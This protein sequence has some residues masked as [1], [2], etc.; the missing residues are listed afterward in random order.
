MIDLSCG[1]ADATGHKVWLG[2]SLFV[3]F[4]WRAHSLRNFFGVAV[5]L[6]CGTGLGGLALAASTQARLV[7]LTDGHAG[8]CELAALNA[9]GN[10]ATVGGTKV[11]VRRLEWG[12]NP[13]LDDADIVTR[14]AVRSND[15]GDGNEDGEEKQPGLS[16]SAQIEKAHLVLVCDA[17]Y[18]DSVVEILVQTAVSLLAKHEAN[19]DTEIDSA[20]SSGSGVDE[21]RS[22]GLLIVSHVPRCAN[23]AEVRSRIAS[24]AAAAGLHQGQ[25]TTA[26]ELFLKEPAVVATGT[27]T[28]S[29]A[30]ISGAAARVNR[31]KLRQDCCGVGAA[32]FVASTSPLLSIEL[33]G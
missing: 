3:E 1:T 11:E 5:E 14:Q 26:E 30:A 6:G 29:A 15:E 22:A 7:V 8:V 32:I 24:S 12:Q 19:A 13:Q 31:E 21:K 16:T 4:L 17:I 2:A 18:D 25:W 28:E 23:D 10:L 33:W 20:S 27:S 9:R